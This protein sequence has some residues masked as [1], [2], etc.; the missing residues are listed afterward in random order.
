MPDKELIRETLGIIARFARDIEDEAMQGDIYGLRKSSAQI[1]TNMKRL[2]MLL[3]NMG[4][5][6]SKS[7]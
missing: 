5:E 2:E 4:G 6:N 7:V 3:K 1:D